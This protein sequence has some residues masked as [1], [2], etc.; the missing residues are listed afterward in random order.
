MGVLSGMFETVERSRD[1]IMDIFIPRRKLVAK[2]VENR[3]IDLIG[4][5]RIGGVT[6]RLNVGG[7]VIEDIEHIVTFV[8]VG[9]DDLGI[10]RNMIGHECIGDDAFFQPKVFGGMAGIDGVKLGFELLAIT[11]GM[12]RITQI[13]IAKDR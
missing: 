8:L 5:M 4:A 7:V 3:K 9:A 6:G 11:T 10:D 1:F 2:E 13:I 12:N